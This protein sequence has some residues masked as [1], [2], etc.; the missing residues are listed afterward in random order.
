MNIGKISDVKEIAN[1]RVSYVRL[2]K[3]ARYHL[4]IEKIRSIVAEAMVR[5]VVK[6]HYG[7][8]ELNILYPKYKKTYI[9]ILQINFNI[10]HAGEWVV[11]AVGDSQVGIDVEKICASRLLSYINFIP[12]RNSF[13]GLT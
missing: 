11:I 1:L 4:E 9:D 8:D 6:R 12:K 10:S 13:F 7:I 2:Q 3:A 5:Y